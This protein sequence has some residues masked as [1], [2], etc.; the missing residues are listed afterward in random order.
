MFTGIIETLGKIKTIKTSEIQVL[1]PIDDVK[2]GDSISINGICLTVRNLKKDNKS[3]LCTFDIS[4]ETFNRTNLK[5]HKVNDFVNIERALKLGSRLDGHLVT[6][7]IDNIS[8]IISISKDRENYW[9]EFSIPEE[10]NKLIAEK[11]SIAIDGISLTVAKKFDKSFTVAIV[12]YTYDHTNLQYRKVSDWVNLE[13]DILARYVDSIL[14]KSN[15]E[16]RL[17]NL[18][19]G[20]W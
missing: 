9:F 13:V 6:G 14:N 20:S 12:P 5:F 17:K 1:I 4:A 16:Q 18:L 3:I 8:K 11:G 2:L 19:G 15:S 10:L 7:H